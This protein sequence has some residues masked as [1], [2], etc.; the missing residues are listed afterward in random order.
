MRA[1]RTVPFDLIVTDIMMPEQDGIETICC[2]R[3]ELPDVKVV[4]I[5]A[6]GNEMFLTD[7]ARLG[8]ARVFEKPLKLADLAAAIEELLAEGG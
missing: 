3:K 5:S 7:A 2:I 4:A 6:P 8:A 1:L